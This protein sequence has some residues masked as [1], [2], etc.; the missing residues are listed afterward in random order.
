[1]QQSLCAAQWQWV[2]YGDL[3]RDGK[4]D[5]I[6]APSSAV[7]YTQRGQP[8]S[9]HCPR[10]SGS[11]STAVPALS[12]SLSLSL[13]RSLPPCAALRPALALHSIVSL[14]SPPT[15][16]QSTASTAQQYTQSKHA[17]FSTRTTTTRACPHACTCTPCSTR[18]TLDTG[19]RTILY[20]PCTMLHAP[21]SS[22]TDIERRS[23][24]LARL[25]CRSS[26]L[27]SRTSCVPNAPCR[28]TATLALPPALPCSA[29]TG[30][31][32]QPA[33]SAAVACLTPA[34]VRLAARHSQSV[35]QP[36][37]QPAS[38]SVRGTTRGTRT[39]HTANGDRGRSPR[40][41][42]THNIGGYVRA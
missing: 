9:G 7:R 4:C 5:A 41:S 2:V 14:C 37:S 19:T 23:A 18:C 8:A 33:V 17:Q 21:R 3:I 31:G 11:G 38:H 29:A 22:T 20:D 13:A 34:P 24:R 10:P 27:A 1:M 32:S 25:A 12:L 28:A 39:L 40:N 36:G 26:H 42:F 30:P 16:M 35:S 15:T 6:D